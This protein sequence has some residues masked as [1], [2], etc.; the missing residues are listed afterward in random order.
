MVPEISLTSQLETR[1]KKRF[2]IDVLRFLDSHMQIAKKVKGKLC[3][4]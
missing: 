3:T 1:F 4:M 2:G